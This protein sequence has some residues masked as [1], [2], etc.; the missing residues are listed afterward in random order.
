MD[1]LALKR[2]HAFVGEKR[3]ISSF[4]SITQ[5]GETKCEERNNTPRLT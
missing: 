4:G 3:G 5:K 1:S 2:F